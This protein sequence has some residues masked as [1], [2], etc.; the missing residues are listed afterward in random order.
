[1]VVKRIL[2]ANNMFQKGPA[3]LNILP[4]LPP[5]VTNIISKTEDNTLITRL[6]VLTSLYDYI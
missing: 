6:C 2:S 1:M 3:L 5:N 4:T